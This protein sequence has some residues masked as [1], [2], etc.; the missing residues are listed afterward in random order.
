MGR[1]AARRNPRPVPWRNPPITVFRFFPGKQKPP[2]QYRFRGYVGLFG[3]LTTRCGSFSGRWRQAGSQFAQG[4]CLWRLLR[5]ARHRVAYQYHQTVCLSVHMLFPG[6]LSR[7]RYAGV[8][9]SGT[10]RADFRQCH[11]RQGCSN[12]LLPLTR[13]F[14]GSC[15]GGSLHPSTLF[16][17]WAVRCAVVGIEP[18]LYSSHSLAQGRYFGLQDIESLAHLVDSLADA[19]QIEPE[20]S[21]DNPRRDE[22]APVH[23]CP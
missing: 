15:G 7:H 11:W 18:S 5:S 21:P 14:L 22:A 19:L 4:P 17:G 9:F 8:C 3:E 1:T 23:H 20:Q 16:R 10:G 13:R 2:E 6:L 12:P